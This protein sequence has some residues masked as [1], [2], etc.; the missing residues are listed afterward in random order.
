M[1]TIAHESG[2]K[3]TFRLIAG[4]GLSLIKG[5]RAFPNH[6]RSGESDSLYNIAKCYVMGEKLLLADSIGSI[7]CPRLGFVCIL[8]TQS[9]LLPR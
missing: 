8:L 6:P 7:F 9:Y 2:Q 5:G 3:C 4:I 1:S